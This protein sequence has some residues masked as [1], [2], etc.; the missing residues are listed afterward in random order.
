[1]LRRLGGYPTAVGPRCL[2]TFHIR[3]CIS[4]EKYDE[5]MKLT[6]YACQPP[7]NL[8][9]IIA[10]LVS[11]GMPKQRTIPYPVFPKEISYWIDRLRKCWVVWS[12]YDI[13]RSRNLHNR[14]PTTEPK[15]GVPDCEGRTWRRDPFFRKYRAKDGSECLYDSSGVLDLWGSSFNFFPESLFFHVC[16]DFLPHLFWHP[17]VPFPVTQVYSC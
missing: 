9:S 6:G 7:D 8:A 1:M 4:K 3:R 10:A 5:Y 15:E 13:H 14:C 16:A 2:P 11:Y 12:S 17:A